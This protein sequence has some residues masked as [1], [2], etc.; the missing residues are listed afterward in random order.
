MRNKSKI[1]GLKDIRFD[2]DTPTLM[3]IGAAIAPLVVSICIIFVSTFEDA[4][5]WFIWSPSALL[6]VFSCIILSLI[7]GVIASI[8]WWLVPRRL[9]AIYPRLLGFSLFFAFLSFCSMALMSVEL[10]TWIINLLK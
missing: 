9:G 1:K 10:H 7:I 4:E 2:Y 3:F 5:G 8:Y 6:T